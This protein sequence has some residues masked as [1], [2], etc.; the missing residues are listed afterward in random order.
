MLMILVDEFGVD[1]EDADSLLTKQARCV[2][3]GRYR[4]AWSESVPIG[5]SSLSTTCVMEYGTI[6]GFIGSAGPW[7]VRWVSLGEMRVCM[8][9]I[10][11]HL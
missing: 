9:D 10:F 7:I 8:Y 1:A 4:R 2:R 3:K 6:K 11:G 5:A